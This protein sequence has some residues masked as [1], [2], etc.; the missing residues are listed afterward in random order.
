MT[1]LH[2]IWKDSRLVVST[3]LKS[4]HHSQKELGTE[5]NQAS[6][7]RVLANL[8]IAR[9]IFRSCRNIVTLGERRMITMAS[10]V[11]SIHMNSA[12]LRQML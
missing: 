8:S 1:K 9:R 6:D 11:K 2:S 5:N 12:I 7:A 3:F 10:G 4:T